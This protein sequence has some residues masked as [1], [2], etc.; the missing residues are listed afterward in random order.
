M[1]I[2]VVRF[3]GKIGI[4]FSKTKDSLQEDFF[5]CPSEDEAFCLKELIE[6]FGR[7]LVGRYIRNQPDDA[8]W[9]RQM[10]VSLK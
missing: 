8:G 10:E 4:S 7:K 1:M 3:G 9:R 5:G 6:K 2:R